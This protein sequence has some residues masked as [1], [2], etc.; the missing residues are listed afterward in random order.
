MSNSLVLLL[1]NI[2]GGVAV[3]SSYALCIIL[4]PDTREVLW[5]EIS[6]GLKNFF[7]I[8]MLIAA[9]GYISYLSITLINPDL[10]QFRNTLFL[11]PNTISI[12][13][14]LFLI[15]ATLWMPASVIYIKNPSLLMWLIMVFS[16]WITAL[17]ILTIFVL[18]LNSSFESKQVFKIISS[19]GLFYISFHC[20]ILDGIIWVAKF[21]KLH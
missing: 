15:S 21:P 12:L 16:L 14:S 13:S 11:G 4:F 8:S 9:V 5:G 17:S 18:S 20:L 19:I 6:G 1:V 2:I 10:G 7:V 3:L